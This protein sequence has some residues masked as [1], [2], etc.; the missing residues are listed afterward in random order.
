MGLPQLNP[1]VLKVNFWNVHVLFNSTKA[2]GIMEAEGNNKSLDG[3]RMPNKS[4]LQQ[5]KPTM[6]VYIVQ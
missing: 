4:C 3:Q 2:P 1:S 6:L 5:V